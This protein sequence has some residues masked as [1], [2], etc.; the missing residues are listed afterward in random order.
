MRR[1]L[2][3]N[4]YPLVLATLI[5]L[6]GIINV[7]SARLSVLFSL[8]TNPLAD[9][10]SSGLFLVCLISIGLI[11]KRPGVVLVSSLIVGL[12]EGLLG[13]A[14]F[15]NTIGWNLLSGISIE[16]SLALFKWKPEG[17]TKTLLT[18]FIAGAL[19]NIMRCFFIQAITGPFPPF[20][21]IRYY[22]SC[23]IGGLVIGGGIGYILFLIVTRIGQRIR[24]S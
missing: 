20:W 23:I 5:I 17:L 18:A 13:K 4:Y 6:G 21:V 7:F 22:I 1:F 14:L 10:I 16:G 11:I 8:L 12:I 15:F 19:A 24:V 9:G 3:A 2:A